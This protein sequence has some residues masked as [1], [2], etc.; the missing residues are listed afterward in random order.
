M[1]A[2]LARE[3]ELF[4]QQR[5]AGLAKANEALRGC[6]EVLASVPELDEFLGRVMAAITRQLGARS[7]TMRVRN[8]EQNTIAMEIVFQD[9]RVMSPAEANYPQGWRNVP[10]DGPRVA[11]FLNPQ[12]APPGL[13]LIPKRPSRRV[14]GPTC[15]GWGSRRC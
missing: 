4:A 10:I 14:N 3:R 9:G 8:V 6:L 1:R 13:W 2:A 5:A 7:S 11:D 12:T 15:W